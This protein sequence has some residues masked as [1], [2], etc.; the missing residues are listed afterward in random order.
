MPSSRRK[1]KNLSSSKQV[2]EKK[3]T[4]KG[5]EK[6]YKFNGKMKDLFSDKLK[7]K[8]KKHFKDGLPE[9]V[10]EIIK[11]DEKELDEQNHQLKKARRR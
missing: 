8:L 5:C 2:G 3:F 7:V 11:E 4:D 6:Q 1:R 9:K 10:E